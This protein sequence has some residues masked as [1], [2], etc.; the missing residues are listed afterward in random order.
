MLC[1]RVQNL[2]SAYCDHELSGTEMLR[3][4]SHLSCCR[5]CRREHEAIRQVKS[6]LGALPAAEP[7]V[8]FSIDL[9]QP[10]QPGQPLWMRRMKA[11]W[12]AFL[13]CSLAESFA[14]FRADLE[15]A[16]PRLALGG[17]LAL[18]V[19]TAALVKQPQHSDAVSAHVP[20]EAVATEDAVPLLEAPSGRSVFYRDDARGS[21]EGALHVSAWDARFPAGSAGYLTRYP[22]PRLTPAY[23]VTPYYGSGR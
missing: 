17:V 6:I 9:L 10:R 21:R 5:E 22:T 15:R 2:L 13:A 14:A 8:S 23:W 1:S 11:R 20:P 19:L 7:G 4:R 3:I 16:G 12:S 18:L